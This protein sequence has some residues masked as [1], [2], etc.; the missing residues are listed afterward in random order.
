MPR[1]G[2]GNRRQRVIALPHRPPI[3][4]DAPY[5]PVPVEKDSV[6]HV[7]RLEAPELVVHSQNLSRDDRGGFDRREWSQAHV[8]Y[9][10]GDR[11]VQS[12]G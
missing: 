11:D 9:S 6:G 8:L 2:S 5:L 7:S 12:E 4:P 3:D 10:A 1:W